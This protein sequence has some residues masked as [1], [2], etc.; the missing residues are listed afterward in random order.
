MSLKQK[1]AEEWLSD[2]QIRRKVVNDLQLDK[3]KNLEKFFWDLKSQ[4]ES[5]WSTIHLNG[6]IIDCG[7]RFNKDKRILATM[8]ILKAINE[9][10]QW[11][12]EFIQYRSL[13]LTELGISIA[14]AEYI[15]AFFDLDDEDNIKLMLDALGILYICSKLYLEPYSI[16]TK[17]V[18]YKIVEEYLKL[19]NNV[20]DA[21]WEEEKTSAEGKLEEFKEKHSK[22]LLK[23]SE[24][25]WDI[26][27]NRESALR[28]RRQ[29]I[30][31]LIEEA[32]WQEKKR[33]E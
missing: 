16:K 10:P 26:L 23:N 3:V 11:T 13:Q 20:R 27:E 14:I 12:W 1:Y 17:K 24:S 9:D 15:Q 33:K 29:I 5:T 30:W 21:D 28:T 2:T 22:T 25:K 4:L 8:L 6:V 31:M 32:D 18:N 7:N 19:K